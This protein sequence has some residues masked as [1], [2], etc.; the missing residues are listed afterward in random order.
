M[1]FFK[2]FKIKKNI[3]NSFENTFFTNQINYSYKKFYISNRK[4]LTKVNN[5]FKNCNLTIVNK[6]LN[7][8]TRSGKKRTIFVNLQKFYSI[9]LFGFFFSNDLNLDSM[10]FINDKF[11]YNSDVNINNNGFN[12]EF[13]KSFPYFNLIKKLIIDDS[14]FINLNN[15]INFVLPL[16][17]TLFT[18]K[19]KKL[20]KKMKAKY[21]KKYLYKLSYVYPKNR[22]NLTLKFM[23]FQSLQVKNYYL[24]ERYTKM[25]ASIIL[26][27]QD[28]LA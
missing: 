22:T 9:Y 19:V 15:L 3:L 7:I 4:K 28:S 17:N 12:E 1:K 5:K 8:S 2:F 14:S 6:F 24:P 23:N 26:A 11:D 27:P 18:I 20:G 21:K 13:F 10:N 16:Y 25:F